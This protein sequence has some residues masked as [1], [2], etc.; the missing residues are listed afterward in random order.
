MQSAE[1]EKSKGKGISLGVGLAIILGLAVYSWKKRSVTNYVTDTPEVLPPIA[2]L[3]ATG[4]VLPDD[5]ATNPPPIYVP[6]ETLQQPV[7][8]PP[9]ISTPLP[10][11]PD[12]VP[13]PSGSP[14]VSVIDSGTVEDLLGYTPPANTIMAEV[15]LDDEHTINYGGDIAPV[16]E[17]PSLIEKQSDYAPGSPI[18]NVYAAMIAVAEANA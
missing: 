11:A 15:T 17:I 2:A 6:P 7:Y 16:S 9:V 10:I 13:A 1:M 4:A 3:P 5:Y 18:Y 12:P 14:T 8:N